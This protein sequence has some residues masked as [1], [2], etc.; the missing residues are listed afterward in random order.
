MESVRTPEATLLPEQRYQ[1]EHPSAEIVHA[2]AL[3]VFGD[4]DLAERWLNTPLPILEGCTPAHYAS[5]GEPAKQREVLT[6]L[7]QI[8][9]GLFS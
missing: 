6:I 2:R 5:S 7:G 4:E 1:L 9:Y 8:D 3:E